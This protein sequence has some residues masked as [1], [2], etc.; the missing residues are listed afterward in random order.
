MGVNREACSLDLFLGGRIIAA[1]P[2]EGFRA[3]HDT[4][5]L[6]A[7]IPADAG[8]SVLELGAGAGIASLCLASRVSGT[9]V[10]GI[11]IDSGLVE[12]ANENAVRNGM[13]DRVGFVTGDVQ[14][15]GDAAATFAHVFFNPPFHPPDGTGSQI[16]RRE[17]AKRDC[18]SSIAAWTTTAI[19]LC[20]TG[21]TVTAILRADRAQEVL[22][23][24]ESH[25][26]LIFPLYPRR[27]EAAKRAIVQVIPGQAG[28]LHYASGLVLHRE[29]G[30][31]KEEAEA[32]LRGGEALR[33]CP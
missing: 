24:A 9:Q 27:G 10:Q 16:A 8:S 1:Q 3:G 29:D 13:A 21:G 6:A 20:K 15:F 12:I 23:A 25:W 5:L 17:L 30:G 22:A 31:N 2:K 26:R 32:V 4:V 28:G 11:E 19:R 7:A 18:G 14:Q 33:M